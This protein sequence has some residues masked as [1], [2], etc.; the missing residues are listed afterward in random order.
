MGQ[1][2]D[3]AFAELRQKVDEAGLARRFG[4]RLRELGEGYAVASML[5]DEHLDNWL[6]RTHGGAIMSLA[7]QALS[8][9]SATI[10]GVPMAIQFNINFLASPAKGE[11]VFATARQVQVGRR[12][13]VFDFEVRDSSNRLL[14]QG[15]ATG[16]CRR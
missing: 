16:I 11:E 15:Q 4:M 6:G 13:A 3:G 1:R 14:A 2:E 9:A 8:A 7:D 10:S 12:V 5:V